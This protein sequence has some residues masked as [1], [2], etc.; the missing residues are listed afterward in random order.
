MDKLVAFTPVTSFDML[1]MLNTTVVVRLH[2]KMVIV[3]HESG[4]GMPNP[5]FSPAM[6]SSLLHV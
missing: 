5:F 1:S 2:N 4:L 6:V 3:L